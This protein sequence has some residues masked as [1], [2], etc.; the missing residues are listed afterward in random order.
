M[1]DRVVV[2]WETSSFVSYDRCA[3]DRGGGSEVTRWGKRGES[4]LTLW[5]VSGW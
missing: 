4:R 2:V 1:D 3:V 5:C